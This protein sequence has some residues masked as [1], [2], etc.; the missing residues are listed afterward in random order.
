MRSH[1]PE[2]LRII[3]LWTF[4]SEKS[5]KRYIVEVEYF[6]ENF[7]GIKFYW[8]GVRLSPDR[9]SILTND[10]EPRT[11]VMSC[12]MIML[13]YYRLNNRYSFGF[14]ASYSIG[15]KINNNKDYPNK[16]FRLYRRM[17][18][19]FFSS[20]KF[21]QAFDFNQ[22]LYLLINK[23]NILYNHLTLKDIEKEIERSFNGNF[24][25]TAIN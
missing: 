11:I 15:E 4:R 12:I 22:S 20:E 3:D 10:H 24:S 18:L 16:R 25:L 9:Y 6:S 1:D 13:N 14:V 2:T 5:N 7:L 17:M 21:M 19:T 8:K 23:Y